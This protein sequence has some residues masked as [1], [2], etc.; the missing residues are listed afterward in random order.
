MANLGFVGLGVMGGE[1]VQRLL[2]KGHAVT[3]YNRTRSKAQRLIDRGMKW[4]KSPREV[5]AAADV[6]FSMV[7]NSSAL[8]EIAEG[9]DGMLAGLSAGKYLVD[10]STVSPAK[11]RELAARVREK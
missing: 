6:T 10:M 5:A 2:D 4:A 9:P 8:G 11:S 7:T 1:M 3:G